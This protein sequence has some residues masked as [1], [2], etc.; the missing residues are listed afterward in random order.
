M[1]NA[2]GSVSPV[3]NPPK[4]MRKARVLVGW[5]SEQEGALWLSGRQQSQINNPTLLAKA[6]L[7][8]EEAEKL[9]GRVKP[10]ES[11]ITDISADLKAYETEWRSSAA[12]A[13]TIK[14]GWVIKTADLSRICAVQVLVHIEDF[15]E[16]TKGLSQSDMKSLAVVCVPVPQPLTLN[17]DINQN[18]LAFVISCDNPN[19]R[20]VGMYAGP[21]PQS[22]NPVYGFN[23]AIINSCMSV[24]ECAGRFILTDG[25]HRAYALLKAKIT[26]VPVLFRKVGGYSEIGF[27]PVP[28]ILPQEVV[29][30]DHPPLLPDYLNDKVSAP[31]EIKS[32]QKIIIVKATQ[33]DATL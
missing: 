7:A 11:P 14:Q 27:P 2:V 1:Q 25:Y 15:G 23:V 5:V 17:A 24:S 18:E 9:S 3:A 22:G 29:L 33:V 4:R 19:L 20:V 30:G 32:T 16:R 6:R 8:R 10:W 26:R 28:G 13:E 21:V 12:N 31:A